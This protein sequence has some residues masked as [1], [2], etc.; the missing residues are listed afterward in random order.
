MNNLHFTQD[1]LAQVAR[2]SV[3]D[4]K[5]VNEYR[6]IENKLGFAYQLCYV[7]LFNRLQ[8][9]S[10]FE[11]IEELVTF[12]AIQLDIPREQLLTYA[13]QKS[14]FFRHQEELR[15]YLLLTKFTQNSEEI[16]K[17]FLFQQA[18]QIQVT[19]ALFMKATD[20]LK[21]KKIL[22]PSSGTITRL[23]QTQREKA[24]TYI[25]EKINA[26]ITPKIQQTLDGLLIVENNSYS[27][28][29]QI[30]D[31]PKKPSAAAIALLSDKLAMIEQTGVLTIKLDWLNNNYKRHF[32]RY[33]TQCD[34]NKLREVTPLHRYAVLVCFLQEAYRDTTDHMFD[35]YAKALNSM[36]TQA[37]TAIATHD[38]SKR[39]LIR[40]CLTVHKKFCNE[41]L[42]IE[43]GEATITEFF[44]KFPQAQLQ[45]QIEEV[46]ILLTSKYSHNLNVVSDR[47]SHMRKLA[48]PL[49][50]KLTF[51]VATETQ[52]ETLLPALDIV[53]DLIRGKKRTI[54]ENTSLAFLPKTIQKAIKE[55]GS[56]NRKRCEAAIYTAIR[57]DIKCGN[58]AITG[59]KRFGQL[60]DFFI[61][62]KQWETM[63]EAFFQKNKMPQD[64]RDVPA[65]LE[66]RLNA[67][68]DYFL[69]HEKNNTFAKIE[70][71]EWLLSKDPAEEFSAEKKQKLEK[72]KNWL[73]ENMR[74]IKLPDLL[75]ET[76]N[77]L[78]FTD[79]Y[80][81]ATR[82][83]E[84]NP[85]DVCNV[86]TT[87]MC[88]GCNIGPYIMPQII[89]GITY[90]QIKRMFDWQM[91]DDAHQE[92]LADIV[93]GIAGIKATRAWGD[94]KTAAGDGQRFEYHRKTLHRTFSHKFNDFAIE[95]YTFVAD[96]YAP[97]YNLVKE[98]TDRDTSKVLDGYLY[99]VSDLDPEE[100][101]FDTGGYD[102]INFAAFAMLGKKFSPRIR[103]IKSQVIY[104]I[105]KER[106]YGSLD[107]L[108]KGEKHI[109]KMHFI[110]DQ[111]DQ[112]AQFYASLEAGH[113]TASTALK[114]LN[115]FTEKNHFHKANVELGRIFKT[116][117][118]LYWMADP[119]K[120]KRTRK[121][122]LK[123]EQIHQ[124][125]RDV[126]YG[127]RGR[128]KGKS[129]EELTSSGNCTII[130]IACII[131]WQAKEIS[132]VIKE[133][134]PET[135]GV[136]ISLLA[137]ISPIAWSNVILYGE[138]KLNRDLVK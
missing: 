63:R 62:K 110:I 101:F 80:L 13:E 52:K 90:H 50:E 8:A 85:D 111:W 96:N 55:D 75:I 95:F 30:K 106:D 12:I 104:K 69:K 56:I 72:L 81:P 7:K 25:L 26:E 46:D 91:T 79:P 53:H 16:L 42:T 125:M 97:F 17:D 10:P 36:Y 92:A 98:A 138:Y 89:P 34:A 93:N 21:E 31:V 131:Y 35:M 119:R 15:S 44:E 107:A 134:D 135:A 121:G 24:K 5:K 84:R 77:D 82:R 83:N 133:H 29:Y 47:F 58:I 73:S 65:Y 124:L 88:Y 127:N 23:I 86:L 94:G 136:D 78:H 64:S 66:K 27:K 137:H 60:E 51:A 59:S 1:Q 99:N 116:E 20:F 48:K 71:E 129:V 3:A 22:N 33:V 57:D 40:A 117:D 4:I 45:T 37:D 11:I 122:L 126:T 6:G 103:N 113:A 38:K 39:Q 61:D 102:E 76:D 28:L 74:T 123:V 128:L 120:R 41:L 14:T 108:L 132:R 109:S 18:Q 112:M 118:I 43:E 87:H 130:M 115:G 2:L 114:R 70:K 67:S 54:P 100:W 68:F 32:N 19:E 9:Q 49:L 105:N